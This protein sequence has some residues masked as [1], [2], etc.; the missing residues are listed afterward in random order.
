MA[1]MVSSTFLG[2]LRHDTRGNT[3]A[4]MAAALI[5]MLG[6][7]GSAVDMAR[8]YVVR[9][10]LQQACDAGV[11]AGRKIMGTEGSS[12]LDAGATAQAQAFFAN[13]FQTGWLGTTAVSFSPSSN[14]PQLVT[15]TAHATVPM[16]IMKFFDVAD[17]PLVVSCQAELDIADTDVMFVLDTTGSMA[18]L[19]SDDQGTC[20][21]YVV[22]NTVQNADG[23]YS[24]TEKSNSRISGLRS[25]VLSFYDTLTTNTNDP[26]THFRFGFVPY[27]ATANVGGLLQ[28]LGYM[29]TG[30]ANYQSRVVTSDANSGSS[31]TY[32]T[33]TGMNATTCAAKTTRSPS[34]PLT[35]TTSGTATQ[36]TGSLNGTT[37]TVT[38]Q[39]LIPNW[40]YQQRS[41]A[42]GQYVAGNAVT[43][44]A[45]VTG[46]TSK[47]NGCVE[48]RNVTNASS[49]DP[50]NP[51][52]E[53]DVDT[54]PSSGN[55]NSYWNPMWQ[56]VVFSRQS[57]P[58]TTSSARTI[59]TRF[60]DGNAFGTYELASYLNELPCPLAAMRLFPQTAQSSATTRSQISNYM[61][62]SNGFRPYG[63]T[64]HDAGMTWGTRLISPTGMFASDTG[65]WTG[66]NQPNRY[67]LFL[68]DGT[69]ETDEYAYT[70]YGLEQF[71]NRTGSGG[72]NTTL[73]TNHNNRFLAA[74]QI[75]KNHGITIFVIG[76]AQTLTT[77]LQTC[78]SPNDAFYASDSATLTSKFQQI[79]QQIAMLR[80]SQ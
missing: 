12:T 40:T 52:L 49:F 36:Y 46:A 44:P 32:A 54:A 7:A 22:G 47:W 41:L 1:S 63:V 25:A 71:D 15:G 59:L 10:R 39:T 27:N 5:P 50:A 19:T 43:N 80:I 70:G 38:Q 77:Q 3:I 9:V 73:A 79:A 51:P 64:F 48:E 55:P 16:T 66:H 67:I 21:S 76:Y 78:A 24:V 29:N 62:A 74:C 60:Q 23:S 68:T 65:A 6:F 61:S 37:C 72:N 33:Y 57:T 58:E 42:I 31:S 53:L 4:I 17:T 75:A 28:P 20:D 11:L 13:N 35:Y 2:R 18:C 8:Q 26:N 45:Q 30:N 34:T 14:N 56:D 69:M